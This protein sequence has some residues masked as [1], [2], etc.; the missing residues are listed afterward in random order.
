MFLQWHCSGFKPSGM[1]RFIT[2]QVVPVALKGHGDVIFRVDQSKKNG[3]H[4]PEYGINIP[5]NI[6]NC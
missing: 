1:R 6:K 2:G 3:L 5:Q 4:D